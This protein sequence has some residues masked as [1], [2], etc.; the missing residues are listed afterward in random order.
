M[1]MYAD[2]LEDT[3]TYIYKQVKKT[4]FLS[5]KLPFQTLGMSLSTPHW[6]NEQPEVCDFSTG[7]S[8]SYKLTSC[9]F[10]KSLLAAK[11]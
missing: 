1:R 10:F 9:H 4:V 8:D 2:I 7:L 6:L 3:W 5:W 11:Y